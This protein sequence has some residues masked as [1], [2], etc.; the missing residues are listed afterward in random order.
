MQW[1]IYLLP[2]QDSGSAGGEDVADGQGA[3]RVDG[4]GYEEDEHAGYDGDGSPSKS[5]LVI[6]GR[7]FSGAPGVSIGGVL[8]AID[9]VN[10]APVENTARNT[11][12][13]YFCE[14]YSRLCAHVSA[15]GPV[16]QSPPIRRTKS[17]LH[18]W[19]VHAVYISID[20][21]PLD[22]AVSS[23]SQYCDSDG[24]GGAG[25]RKGGGGAGI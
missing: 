11:E 2:G 24:L 15:D 23:I 10:S 17:R 13:L 22:A 20:H 19:R 1:A 14:F 21:A 9:C 5:S 12:L 4:G 16:I 3:S 18:R 6:C 25:S 8:G 7:G